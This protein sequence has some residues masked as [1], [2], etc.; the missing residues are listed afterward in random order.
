MPIVLKRIRVYDSVR[1]LIK[2]SLDIQLAACMKHIYASNRDADNWLG[3]PAIFSSMCACK[4]NC[5]CVFTH[6]SLCIFLSVVGGLN[7]VITSLFGDLLL[8]TYRS[9]ACIWSMFFGLNDC[10]EKNLERRLKW[11]IKLNLVIFALE[12]CL[13]GGYHRYI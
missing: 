3:Y 9:T 7:S 1:A 12:C 2:I 8:L 6:A 13:K 5:V 10:V 4:Y 11:P